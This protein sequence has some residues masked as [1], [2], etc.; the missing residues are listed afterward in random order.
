MTEDDYRKL[1]DNVKSAQAAL[2]ACVFTDLQRLASAE[3]NNTKAK[4]AEAYERG[5]NDAWELAKE[6]WNWFG[7]SDEKLNECFGTHFITTV[8]EMDVKEALQKFRE[9]TQ[10][11]KE[12]A[13]KSELRVGDEIQNT[14]KPSVKLIV[15]KKNGLG[16]FG[17]DSDGSVGYG[18]LGDFSDYWKKTGRHFD[19]IDNILEEMNKQDA[20]N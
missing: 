11:Q 16:W 3:S 2:N 1:L 8:Y 7:S 20:K 6:I 12:E 17:F 5:L 13:E 14:N 4:I 18:S 15:T 19:Q 9:Y 10:E